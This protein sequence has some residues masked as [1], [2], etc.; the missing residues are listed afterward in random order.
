MKEG[1]KGSNAKAV[2]EAKKK[3]AVD[4]SNG[5]EEEFLLFFNVILP[6][7]GISSSDPP[8]FF[9]AFLCCW[10]QHLHVDFAG[11]WS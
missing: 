1:E 8:H 7:V 2:K 3:K 9:D 4:V 5:H 10:G 6:F 11:L